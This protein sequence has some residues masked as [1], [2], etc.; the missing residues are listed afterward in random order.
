[1]A[2]VALAGGAVALGMSLH[3]NHDAALDDRSAS[4]AHGLDASDGGLGG[5]LVVET[6]HL[7]AAAGLTATLPDLPDAPSA[8]DVPETPDVPGSVDLPETPDA[9]ASASASASAAVDADAP[10]TPELRMTRGTE[11][12]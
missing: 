8:P 5:S 12:H 9:D 6:D 10:E 3:A 2:F 1:A 7:D 4:V 11:I